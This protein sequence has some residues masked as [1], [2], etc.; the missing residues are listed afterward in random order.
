[1][2]VREGNE[3]MIRITS[4]SWSEVVLGDCIEINDLTYSLKEAW[5]YI[6]YSDTGSLTD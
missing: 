5:P 1:M 3:R 6:N 2:A 4:E